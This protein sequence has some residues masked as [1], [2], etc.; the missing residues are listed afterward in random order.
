[1]IISVTQFGHRLNG[2]HVDVYRE[3]EHGEKLVWSGVT[4]WNGAAR[5]NQLPTGSYR[6][7]AK[8]QS[9]TMFLT[10]DRKEQEA[11][12]WCEM[13]VNPQQVAEIPS[14]LEAPA[15][16]IRLREFRG[17]VQDE[18]EAVIPKLKIEVFRRESLDK[19][20][21]AETQSDARGEFS[22]HLADGAYVATFSYTGFRKRVAAFELAEKGWQGLRLTMIVAGFP[23]R[24]PLPVEWNDQAERK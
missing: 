10:V 18:N 23:A 16:S 13:K 21:V 8:K 7:F 9:T 15:V 17:I 19:G 5:P 14:R 4:D 6:V 1:M 2:V 3:I 11:T 22:A 12:K 24:D 20:S